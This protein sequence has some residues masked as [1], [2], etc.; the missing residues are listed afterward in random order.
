MILLRI[1]SWLP[2]KLHNRQEPTKPITGSFKKSNYQKTHFKNGKSTKFWYK[3]CKRRQC[4]RWTDSNDNIKLSWCNFPM[5]KIIGGMDNS[6]IQFKWISLI[7]RVKSNILFIIR[8]FYSDQSFFI[9]M[10]LN[11][12]QAI[13]KEKNI[14][15]C[16]PTPKLLFCLPTWKLHQDIKKK[17]NYR[18]FSSWI[19]VWGIANWN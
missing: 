4:C 16:I 3:E 1:N 9:K 7:M 8:K 17:R 13:E 15:F 2:K 18:L 12:F 5:K 19:L 10:L 14:L 6:W 11:H